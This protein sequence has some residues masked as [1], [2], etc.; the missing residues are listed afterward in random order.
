MSWWS[1]FINVT[2]TDRVTRELEEEQRFHIDARI[3]DLMATGMTRE[4]AAIQA[5]RQFGPRLLMREASLDVKLLNRLESLARDMRLGLR[6][7]R[8]D[9]I[10]SSAAIISLGLA[11]GACTAAFA[12]IDAL[13]L[14]ELPVRDPATLVVLDRDGRDSDQR[15][16]ALCSYPLFDR[17]RQAASAHLDTFGMSPQS[18]RQAILPD[19]GGVEEKVRTQFVS[20]NTFDV[21]G[22]TPALGRLLTP[23]DDRTPG[24]HQTAV[25]SHAFWAS[26]FGADPRI[27]GR[28]IQVEQKPYQ[29]VGVAQAGFSGAH[30]G[31]L[32]DVWL[33]N[34]MF[35]PDSMK[36]PTWHWLQV[37]GRLKPGVTREAA[38]PIVQAAFTNFAL[39]QVAG[40]PN[41]ID[42]RSRETELAIT[43]RDASAGL[44]QVRQM[45]ERPL[46]ALAMIAGCVLLIAC[47]NVANLL[48]ARGAARGRE[49]ALRASIGA[50]R[51]RLMQQ[52]LV[53]SSVLTAAATA[54]GIL[55]AIGAARL[56][57][58]LISTS[59]NPLYVDVRLD[60]RVLAFVA[61]LGC[62]TTVLFGLVPAMRA[63]GAMRGGTRFFGSIS[64][65]GSGG[66]G[67]AHTMHSG[68]VRPLV[69]LQIGF[70][71]MVLFVAALLLRSFD[72]L[73]RVDLGFNPDRVTLLSIE[74]RG[75]LEG[76]RAREVGRQL[77]DRVRSL[78]GVE[79][80]S[81]S[82][83]ALF[84]GW[85]W[86]NDVDIPGRGSTSSLRLAVSPG[87]FKAM[88][89]RIV[90]GREFAA[91]EGEKTSPM[92]VVV[93]VAFARKYFPGERAVGQRLTGRNGGPRIPIDIV[94]VV[95]NLRDGSIRE[96][97]G[98]YVFS[99]FDGTAGA[100]Q[101]RSSVDARTLAD[102][103][104]EELP[105]IHPG[106]RL[107]DV[108]T[109]SA[110][111][112]NALLRERLLAVLSGFFAM[113]G[114]ALAAVGL[115]G[116][117]SYAVVRR[118]REIGIRLTLGAR[119]AAVIHSVL[120][121]IA[122]AVVGGVAAGLAGGVYLARF[123]RALLFEIEPIS[124][125]GFGL[126]VVCLMAVALAAA[127]PA[128]R[129]ATRV[130]PAEA[131]RSE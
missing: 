100:V 129:R 112:N 90:D 54:L 36:S 30:P 111:V 103:V 58:G 99:P 14:R 10:V 55:C 32:T 98:P 127:W 22:V 114:L 35:P 121:R 86:G 3:E 62:I 109:Q 68:V 43:L 104:R 119:P 71:V 47:S 9:A 75:P 59:E 88:G 83:W 126:P 64:A 25:I 89:A 33:P 125:W 101:V 46:I 16:S 69:A 78:S 23:A 49:M 7:L 34:M 131:L 42:R 31:L 44:S 123:V 80:A 1:R 60:W 72:R 113:L 79:Q 65:L 66:G 74:S 108:T 67:R 82:C 87:F 106:L 93:N 37:W 24:A 124:A 29:I 50:G 84:K 52:V 118:T 85:Q 19:A 63:A 94:G 117:A 115:Y 48:L 91:H 110:L 61:A 41:P 40:R 116:V 20:G 97:V 76:D 77:V 26:R 56:I 8:K 96:A 128:A 53:E 13:I 122:I 2:R 15:T 18:L 92:P 4:A 73:I 81:M 51:A 27:V 28:W 130:D 45:F 107:V 70:S 12:L 39:E 120:G 21:L 95:D 11:I 5:E 102:R 17:I 57:I 38:R 105:R 6:L